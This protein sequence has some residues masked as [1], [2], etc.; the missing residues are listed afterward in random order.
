MTKI[1]INCKI[2]L[3]VYD[4]DE[5]K[6]HVLLPCCHTICLSCSNNLFRERFNN[7][8]RCFMCRA[9]V[10]HSGINYGVLDIITLHV[11]YNYLIVFKI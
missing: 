7:E 9:Q 3:E 1:T 10:T 5:H 4:E 2:C 6:P 8:T 11:S